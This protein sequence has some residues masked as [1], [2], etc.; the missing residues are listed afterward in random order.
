MVVNFEL[1][2]VPEDYVHRIGRTGRAGSSG[3]AVSLVDPIA[4][5]K[6]LRAIEKVIKRRIERVEIAGIT[7]AE[8]PAGAPGQRA[9]RGGKAPSQRHS[10]R[11]QGDRPRTD[12]PRTASGH[13]GDAK[14]G[15]GG[16]GNAP[17]RD[18]AAS[19]T[20]RTRD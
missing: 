17:R 16:R 4:E 5:D 10:H 3:G 11:H 20:P 1:P 6:Q 18:R 12:A 14:R 13:A 7:V 8:K 2:H 9:P 19:G 15:S